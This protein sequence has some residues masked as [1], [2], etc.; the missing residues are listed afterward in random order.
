MILIQYKNSRA[1]GSGSEK[2]IKKKKHFA[3]CSEET[4]SLTSLRAV[5]VLLLV[6]DLRDQIG[7]GDNK[8][9][10][11]HI[12]GARRLADIAARDHAHMMRA[13]RGK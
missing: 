13:F 4:R 9:N 1:G 7:I 6:S 5:A 8:K 2:K 11:K 10:M 12:K 3:K